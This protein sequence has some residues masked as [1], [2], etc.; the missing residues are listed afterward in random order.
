MILETRAVKGN[1]F[2]AFFQSALSNSFT[3]CSSGVFVSSV[4]QLL[5]DSFFYS[6]SSYQNFRTVRGDYLCVNMTRGT[7]YHQAGR[8]KLFELATC[9]GRTTDTSRFL[10]HSVTL[11]LLSLFGTHDFVGVTN[12]L[13]FVRLRTTVGAQ[14]SSN[15]ADQLFISAFQHDFSLRRTFCSDTRRQ[16]MINR[17]RETQSQVYYVP[18][19]RCT[20]TYTNQL[21]LL[22]EAFGNT[23]NH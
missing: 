3:N 13:A 5:S 11:L 21:Q 14:V 4:L 23:D 12:T 9:A 7:M 22:S 16:L 15:L 20:I 19:D 6:R 18:F 1:I 10:I 17:M 8:T 2:D